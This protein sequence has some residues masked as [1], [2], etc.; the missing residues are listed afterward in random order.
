M[1]L[2]LVSIYCSIFSTFF[3]LTF[4]ADNEDPFDLSFYTKGAAIGDS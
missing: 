1:S 4:A 3:T 2:A